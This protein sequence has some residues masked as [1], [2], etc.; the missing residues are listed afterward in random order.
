MLTDG[1]LAN[2]TK[3]PIPPNVGQGAWIQYEFSKAQT[4]RAITFVTK[5]RDEI[6]A[7][8][9]GIGAPDTSVEASDDGQHFR[10]IARLTRS[11]G[12]TGDDSDDAP[13]YTLSF[14]P[15]T[16]KYFRV[17]FI[18]TPPPL[19]P[20]WLVGADLMSFGGKNR[21][22]TIRLRNLRVGALHAGARVNR[23]E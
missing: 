5:T 18:R 12:D 21:A 4:I 3:I 19:A 17:N 20:Y 6:Q 22:S 11:T 10:E 1:D 16:A 9:D 13:E 14:P 7:A 15:A 8:I 2:A 23:W